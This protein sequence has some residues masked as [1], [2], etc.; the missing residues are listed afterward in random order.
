MPVRVNGKPRMNCSR[1]TDRIY[2]FTLD[3]CAR[4]ENAKCQKFFTKKKMVLHRIGAAMSCIAASER[5]RNLRLWVAKGAAEGKKKNTTVVMLLPVS[6]D[7]AS[8][9]EHIYLQ[10]GVRVHFL[11]ERV[12]FTN[13][14]CRPMQSMVR[15]ERRTLPVVCGPRWWLCSPARSASFC[16]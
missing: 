1:K 16:K 12:K 10:P 2:H 11:P 8:F 15:T 9:Q 3:A 6:T 14:L 13:H 7:A 5:D 4:P